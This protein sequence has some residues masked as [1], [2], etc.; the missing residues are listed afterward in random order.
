M[1]GVPTTPLL[2]TPVRQG[3]PVSGRSVSSGMVVVPPVPLQTMVRQSPATCAGS[4]DVAMFAAVY[5]VPHTKVAEHAGCSQ[6][7][8]VPGHSLGLVHCTQLPMPS[9]NPDM[10]LMYVLHDESSRCGDWLG[11]PLV[12]IGSWQSPILAGTSLSSTTD[13]LTPPTHSW[14]RQSPLICV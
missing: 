13:V 11:V 7:S 2:H 6:S 10:L 14:S 8:V 9:Q 1:V 4:P 3:V 5:V 12:Q